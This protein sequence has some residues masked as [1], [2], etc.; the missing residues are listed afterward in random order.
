MKKTREN[1]IKL[2]SHL[3]EFSSYQYINGF[4]SYF[5]PIFLCMLLSKI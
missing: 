3:S 1:N 5:L 2:F 4:I